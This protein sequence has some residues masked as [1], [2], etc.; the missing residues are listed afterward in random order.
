M[1]LFLLGRRR[2]SIS[3]GGGATHSVF[4]R[5]SPDRIPTRQSS[6][7][8]GVRWEYEYFQESLDLAEGRHIYTN[9]ALWACKTDQVPVGVLIQTQRKPHSR[10]DVLGLGFVTHWVDGYFRI[11]NV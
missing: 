7:Y 11:E 2:Q 1:K 9:V 5:I 8:R 6:A 10:Y 4:G 3:R